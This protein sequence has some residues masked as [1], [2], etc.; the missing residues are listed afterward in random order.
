M[1]DTDPTTTQTTS[2]TAS[3]PP[4]GVAPPE[5]S[6]H[7]EEEEYVPRR[8][9]E[10]DLGGLASAPQAFEA[11]VGGSLE[12]SRSVTLGLRYGYL[13]YSAADLRVPLAVNLSWGANWAEAKG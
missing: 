11:R 5:T 6:S 13:S 7:E 12:V 9:T 8:I 1:S 3:A 2:T 10:D 4:T